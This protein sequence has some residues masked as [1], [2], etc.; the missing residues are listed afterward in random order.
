M[1][2]THYRERRACR[3]GTARRPSGGTVGRLPAPPPSRSAIA[4]RF[5]EN[6]ANCS[7]IANKATRYSAMRRQFTQI[8]HRQRAPFP[9]ECISIYRLLIWRSRDPAPP[10]RST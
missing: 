4:A 10:C 8:R 7:R 9:R 1:K 5:T 6:D 2:G 3:P